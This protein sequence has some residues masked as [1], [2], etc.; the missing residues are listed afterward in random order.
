MHLALAPLI[1]WMNQ[2]V[3]QHRG[4]LHKLH[5]G[6]FHYCST[7]SYDVGTPRQM[8]RI[9]CQACFW[10]ALS[11][12]GRGRQYL[13]WGVVATDNN[14]NCE[15]IAQIG[16]VRRSPGRGMPPGHRLSCQADRWVVN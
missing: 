4:I 7:A 10:I 9:S 2:V 12:A 1:A 8:L 3:V 16:T 11:A 6:N 14:K 5:R 15:L 13:H